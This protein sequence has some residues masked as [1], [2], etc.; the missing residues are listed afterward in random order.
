MT[1]SA[2]FLADFSNFTD[3]VKKAEASLEGFENSAED[4]SKALGKMSESFLG[5]KVFE[6]A[7]LATK[8]VKDIGGATRLTEA[9]QE[10]LNATLTEAL[11]KYRVLGEEAPEDMKKLAAETTKAK[12]A[13]TDI[14]S[15][16]GS[17]AGAIGIGFSIGAVVSFGKSVLDSASQIHD[18]AE[19]LGIS[20]E[21]TQ[22]FKAAAEQAGSSIEAVGTALTK[23]NQNLAEGNKSTVAALQA[24]GLSFDDIRQMRPEDAFLAITDAVQK[25][26][27][28]MIQTQV[29]MELF[30]RS[31]A[32]LLP[33]IKEGFRDAANAADKMSED[34]I[35]DLEAAQDA[36]EKLKN[37]VT[38]VTGTMI[39]DALNFLNVWKRM[40]DD[41]D[42]TTPQAPGPKPLA[43]NAG[44]GLNLP[45]ADE[46]DRITAALNE[47]RKA[48][49]AHG[50][51]VKATAK[52]TF[53]LKYNTE[54]LH[55]QLDFIGQKLERFVT[56]AMADFGFRLKYVDGIPFGTHIGSQ[57]EFVAPKVEKL[58]VDFG[59]LAQALSGLAQ[60]SGST[61][62][63]MVSSLS[64]LVS[65]ANVAQK[66]IEQMRK[67][68]SEKGSLAGILDMASGITGIVSSAIAAGK[69]VVALFGLFDR[70]KGRDLVVDFA[71]TFGG[72]DALHEKL[73]MLGEDGERLWIKL[74]QGVGRNNPTQAQQAIDEVTQ[75][76]DEQA[77]K[78][79]DAKSATEEQAQATIETATE[80]AKALDE[81][82]GKLDI[83]KDQ[84]KEWGAVV[85]G[86]LQALANAIRA[87]PVPSPSGGTSLPFSAGTSG[88]SKAQI[89]VPVYLDGNVLTESVAYHTLN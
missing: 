54:G 12:V 14:V 29:A 71:E 45:D 6:E 51:A 9:E 63:G 60:V 46:I 81:L 89:V 44:L 21:A 72:F 68:A 79:D 1:V 34:T 40:K 78:S 15:T 8:A 61:F 74:T 39:V 80:A 53:D 82:G 47:Q 32:E 65:S 59:D 75:A 3:A 11:A 33:A 4:V 10:R 13:T 66:A 22:G 30:G 87:L 77:K 83:S 27:D 28:P 42:R 43:T 56:P 70:N 58:T 41:I 67:G 19:Q 35:K 69:A 36:W 20:A 18:M 38:I 73:L 50:K 26:P 88:G 55:G 48:L 2:R 25:I 31:A 85:T 16:A 62:S 57:V 7:M 5:K 24:A 17:L 86:E 23:M 37:K 84:W 64:Q 52:E 49:D 76:L